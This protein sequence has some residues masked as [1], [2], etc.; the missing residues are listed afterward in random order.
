MYMYI[1][2][3]AYI[4]TYINMYIYIYTHYIHIY[5]Y[6]YI[7]IYIPLSAWVSARLYV[8]LGGPLGS[9]GSL[10]MGP[11]RDETT[12]LHIIISSI[13]IIVNMIDTTKHI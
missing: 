3:Y 8:F 2:I 11:L 12:A 1:Y 10:Y 13:N 7:Y 6:I 4:T 9:Q 5:I